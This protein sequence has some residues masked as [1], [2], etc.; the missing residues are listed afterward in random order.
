MAKKNDELVVYNRADLL[1]EVLYKHIVTPMIECEIQGKLEA[2]CRT[3]KSMVEFTKHFFRSADKTKG[4]ECIERLTEIYFELIMMQKGGNT[5]QAQKSIQ[6][7]RTK[8]F[9]EI[10]EIKM[11]IYGCMH[12]AKIFV[13][14][15][16][17]DNRPV[18]ARAYDDIHT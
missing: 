13:L 9:S 11:K 17:E 18:S 10:S 14:T 2:Y 1:Y 3:V 8:L 5:I 15:Q 7:N 4:K 6:E 12:S 16:K